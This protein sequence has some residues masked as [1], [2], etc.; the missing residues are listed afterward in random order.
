MP[1]ANAMVPEI[2]Y[3]L[4]YNQID[5]SLVKLLM[6]LFQ[7]YLPSADF[8]L[9]ISFMSLEWTISDITLLY[10]INNNYRPIVVMCKNLVFAFQNKQLLNNDLNNGSDV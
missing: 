2:L 10:K 1:I 5:F 3:T 4:I 6:G 7:A 8:I 9:L